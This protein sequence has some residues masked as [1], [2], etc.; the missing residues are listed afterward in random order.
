MH[1]RACG[2]LGLVSEQCKYNLLTRLVELEIQLACE[3][4]GLGLVPAA[5]SRAECCRGQGG[6]AARPEPARERLYQK[7][8]REPWPRARAVRELGRGSNASRRTSPSRGCS[9]PA[10]AAPIIG[11]RTRQQLDA[12]LGALDLKLDANVLIEAR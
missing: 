7:R 4:Y 10:V 2:S 9:R 8:S 6:A 1:A 11:P 3:R 12:V 5:H